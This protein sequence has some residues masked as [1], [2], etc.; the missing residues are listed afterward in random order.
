MACS[1]RACSVTLEHAH[2]LRLLCTMAPVCAGERLQSLLACLPYLW[3]RECCA[4]WRNKLMT[5]CFSC[6]RGS[7]FGV[8]TLR[9]HNLG[10][11]RAFA[12]AEEGPEAGQAGG[13]HCRHEACQHG[14]HVVH[15]ARQHGGAV[16]GAGACT[17]S[18]R[19]VPRQGSYPCIPALAGAQRSL[20]G[21]M[22][23][24]TFPPGMSTAAQCN[25]AQYLFG[26]QSAEV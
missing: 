6:P 24:N 17:G 23:A 11:H 8:A 26:W 15:M 5:A 10:T 1:H 13:R 3:R 25:P 19:H 16:R 18:C 7:S 20:H 22:R 9:S 14:S 12:V 2:A 4:A 21:R